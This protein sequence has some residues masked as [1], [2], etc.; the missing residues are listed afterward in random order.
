MGYTPPSAESFAPIAPYYDEL[1]R[2]VPYSM[3]TS[4]YELLL[5]NQDIWPRR[6]LDVCCGTGTMCEMLID[7]G[8]EV[9]GFDI[10]PEMIVE[11]KKKAIEKGIKIRYEVTDA[12]TFDL[13]DTFDGAFSFFD[14]LNNIL[15]P[16]ELLMAFKRVVLHLPPGG[17]W[18]F[19]L[20][21]AYAFEKQMFDQSDLRVR[22]ALKYKWIGDYD[23]GTRL[24]V[25][26]MQFWWQGEEFLEVHR[27]RAFEI[28]EVLAMLETAGF[29]DLHV[30]HS[31]TLD[32]PRKNSDRVHFTAVRGE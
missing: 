29:V 26:N 3:W 13:A 7:E 23:P 27:Q 24:I 19:D 21:T 22:T 2:N 32:R 10:A 12:R 1:M 15:D 14:S 4:Y 28:D 9:T 6:L 8:Y 18:V 17:S 20:N 5:A 11:A 30:Y 31:Y 16:N 25:V